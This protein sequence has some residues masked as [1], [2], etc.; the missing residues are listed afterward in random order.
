MN[1]TQL[2]QLDR[3]LKQIKQEREEL[4]QQDIRLLLE[5]CKLEAQKLLRDAIVEP[6]EGGYILRG[7]RSTLNGK[8]N[9]VFYPLYQTLASQDYWVA[10]LNNWEIGEP[11]IAEYLRTH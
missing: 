5:E 11:T 10:E 6:V 7:V 2:K 4:R 8:K 9:D 3:R 1:S